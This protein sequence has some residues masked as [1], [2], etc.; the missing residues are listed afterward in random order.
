LVDPVNLFFQA[1]DPVVDFFVGDF[2]VA[3]SR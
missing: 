1:H 2:V 3:H